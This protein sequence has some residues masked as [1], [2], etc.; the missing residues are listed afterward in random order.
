MIE[1]FLGKGG[2]ANVFLARDQRSHELVVLKRMNAHSAAVPELRQRF[3]LEA[4]A[5]ESVQHPAVIRVMGIEEPPDEPPWMWLEA[6]KGESLGEYLARN[7][8]LDPELA[9][10]LAREAAHALEAVH[11]VGI[12]H[13]DVKPD[14]LFLVGPQGDPDHLKVLDFG[15]AR[16]PDEEHDESSTSILGTAQYMAPEQILVEPVDGRSDVYAL[17]VVLFRMVTGHLPFDAHNPGDLLRHQLFSPVPPPSW[18][19]DDLPPGLEELILRATRKNPR[20][21]YAS[22]RE[23]GS[24]L[25][26]L[27][28]IVSSVINEAELA[29]HP[30]WPLLDAEPP[31]D[32]YEPVTEKG[33]HAARVLAKEFGIYAHG[34]PR[35]STAQPTD[36]DAAN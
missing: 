32:A 16:M 17:G 23:L 12:V 13:R 15:M 27:V 26:V 34:A 30:A 21:R 8:R 14:N 31:H 10:R 19:V 4:R 24:A 7:E 5:L 2:T 35:T 20:H 6:L 33:L 9:L 25:D 1:G 11:E 3:V 36:P 28:G 18:L 22:M 29:S